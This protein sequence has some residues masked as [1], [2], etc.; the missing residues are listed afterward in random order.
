[1]GLDARVRY[2]K[3]VIK[4]SF[5][6]LLKIKPIQKITVKEICTLSEINRATFYKYY[7]DV[8]DLLDKLEEEL[9]QELLKT[10]RESTQRGFKETFTLI[11][12]SI[13]ADAELYETLF[14]ENGDRVFPN[15]VFEICYQ[16]IAMNTDTKFKKLTSSQQKWL[17][18]YTAK[19]CSGILEEWMS[20]GMKEP[21]EEIVYYAN[22]LLQS[23]LANC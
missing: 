18:H 8:Y 11:L 5:V 15:R 16:N 10:V 9:L 20:T 14:S 4:D 3:M 1:M 21:I 17:Y 19:G 13:K 23:T 6:S 12:V 22:K 2:T 7:C